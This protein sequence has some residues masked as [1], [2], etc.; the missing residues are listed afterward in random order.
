MSLARS[1]VNK[2]KQASTALFVCDIQER[3]RP[4]IYQFPSLI[5]TAS[6][7]LQA[8][9]ILN[10]PVIVTEQ[11][12][13]AL[14]NTVP[15][16]D[17]GHA[18]MVVPKSLFS[19]YVPEVSEALKSKD[20]KSVVLLGIESHVCVLQTTLDLLENGYDVHVLADGVSSMNYPEIDVA[21]NR[22]RQ[23]GANITTSESI[24]FQLLVDAKHENFKQISNLIKQFKDETSNNKLLFRH[25]L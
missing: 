19:M 11:N 10:L 4:M 20:I 6:K 17:I 5:S 13:K 15:E 25:S 2:I 9:K 22:M 3:F 21:L 12:S 1:M 16:L 7:M 23:A 8:S 14:G 24:L 18:Q